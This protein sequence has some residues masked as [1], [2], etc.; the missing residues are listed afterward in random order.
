MS[1][2]S[3]RSTGP[4]SAAGKARASR[5]AMTHGLLSRDLLLPEE[6]P[7][8]WTAL[9]DR[10]LLELAPVGTLEQA[11]VERIA[12]AIWRQKRLVRVETARIKMSQRP[13]SLSRIELEELLGENNKT[14]QAEILAGEG[15]KSHE[16]VLE[17]IMDAR[18]RVITELDVL[19]V[20][21][22]GVWKC[23][24]L[25]AKASGSVQ[26]FLEK[27]YKGSIDQYLAALQRTESRIVDAYD[28]AQIRK[29]AFSLPAA[30][31][32]MTRYQSALDN[33]LYKAMRALRDA[34]RF[35]RESIEGTA[36]AVAE[37]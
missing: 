28:K 21:Y 34:Q 32:L 24:L 5:N 27:G 33:D 15:R 8:E 31:E 16:A 3:S 14:L 11:L 22:P 35:R 29:S 10:L 37:T 6:D 18:A 26:V 20:E 30:P 25:H 9:L 23:L 36:Q 2:A 12:V 19:R 1:K 17:E 7:S 13:D 4:R